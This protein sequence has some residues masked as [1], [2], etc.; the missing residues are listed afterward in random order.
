MVPSKKCKKKLM[1][2]VGIVN[3]ILQKDIAIMEGHEVG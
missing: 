1:G 3:K 2:V